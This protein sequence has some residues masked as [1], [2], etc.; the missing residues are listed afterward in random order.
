MRVRAHLCGHHMDRGTILQ[1]RERGKRQRKPATPVKEPF[2]ACLHVYAHKLAAALWLCA[3]QQ[4]FSLL[5]S[6]SL[7]RCCGSSDRHADPDPPPPLH[8]P[9]SPTPLHRPSLLPPSTVQVR[10]LKCPSCAA[11]GVRGADSG[12]STTATSPCIASS[13][14]LSFSSCRRRGT[15]HAL[16][17]H[18][19]RPV[20]AAPASVVRS[21]SSPQ[22]PFHSFYL[23]PVLPRL[24]HLTYL[25]C[26]RTHARRTPRPFPHLSKPFHLLFEPCGLHRRPPP[27]HRPPPFPLLSLAAPPM[28]SITRVFLL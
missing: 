10:I 9:S 6:S 26:P 2:W 13:S 11:G 1:A 23:L 4:L 12:T 16:L 8:P 19:G 24:S 28:P 3:A 5:P 21:S 18:L 7:R 22:Q 15:A 25:T 14:Q 27:L 20:G 17:L